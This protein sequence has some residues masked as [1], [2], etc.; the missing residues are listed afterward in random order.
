MKLKIEVKVKSWNNYPPSPRGLLDLPCIQRQLLLDAKLFSGTTKCQKDIVS[1]KKPSLDNIK[2]HGV[3]GKPSD[4]VVGSEACPLHL[5]A[6][7][8]LTLACCTYF[9][10]FFPLPLIQEKQVVG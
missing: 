7:P 2:L 9:R 6:D 3:H 4:T 5:Q 1:E 8:R 10:G